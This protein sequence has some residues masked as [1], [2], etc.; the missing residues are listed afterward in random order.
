MLEHLLIA[1]ASGGAV[2]DAAIVALNPSSVTEKQAIAIGGV[3]AWSIRRS[4]VPRTALKRIVESHPVLRAMTLGHVWFGPMLEVLTARE[5]ASR[6]SLFVRLSMGRSSSIATAKVHSAAQNGADEA[7][8]FSSAVP[9]RMCAP[10]PATHLVEHGL[11]SAQR[12]SRSHTQLQVV[13]ADVCASE[14]VVDMPSS[15]AANSA[16]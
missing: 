7:G 12:A 2:N 13:P 11:P 14:V 1:D 4:H 3:I 10:V 16:P 9:M 5:V 6:P 15:P 8:S